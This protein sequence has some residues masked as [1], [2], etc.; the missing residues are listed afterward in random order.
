MNGNDEEKKEMTLTNFREKMKDTTTH[1]PETPE[2]PA[3][4]WRKGETKQ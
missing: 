2:A 4:S 3:F 1:D